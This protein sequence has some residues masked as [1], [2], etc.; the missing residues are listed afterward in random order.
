[1]LVLF[2]AVSVAVGYF[3]GVASQ[4]TVTSVS[5]TMTTTTQVT[6]VTPNGVGPLNQCTFAT[7]CLAVNPLG[8]ILTLS[9]NETRVYSNSSFT[10]DV[11]EFNPT[12]SYINLSRSNDW[13]VASLPSFWVCYNGDPPYG[14]VVFRGYYTL[15]NIS[16]A[17]DVIH[18]FISPA[19]LYTGNATAFSFPPM[20]TFVA[21]STSGIVLTSG[22]ASCSPLASCQIYAIDGGGEAYSLWSSRLA[23]YTI[24]AGDEWGDLTLLHFMVVDGNQTA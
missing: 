23:V 5:T 11:S 9:V 1:M 6:T 15:Q 4:R 22:L 10:F 17:E 14:I 7:S 8:L 20:S 12:A 18:F 21:I 16:S 19:C 13:Y 3:A 24:A 2:I